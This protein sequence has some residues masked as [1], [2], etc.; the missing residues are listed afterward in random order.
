MSGEAA[1]E[2]RGPCSRLSPLLLCLPPED[3]QSFVAGRV[4]PHSR[5]V[6]LGE[7]ALGKPDFLWFGDREYKRTHGTI[8]ASTCDGV[9]DVFGRG[10]EIFQAG[11]PPPV[12]SP[13]EFLQ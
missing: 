1:L 10:V 4:P 8:H 12:L 9:E 2:A 6:L 5:S 11:I 3:L 7:I 13:Y